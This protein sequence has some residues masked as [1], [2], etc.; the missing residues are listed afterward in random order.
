M[1]TR[2]YLRRRMTAAV[3]RRLTPTELFALA[4]DVEQN[5]L[6]QG[7]HIALA[8]VGRGM[9]WASAVFEV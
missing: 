7:E 6:R 1:D 5:T 8:A 4:R 2:D 3:Y 9:S